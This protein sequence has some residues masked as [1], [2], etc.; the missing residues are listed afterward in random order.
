MEIP[1]VL[2]SRTDEIPT[3][4]PSNVSTSVCVTH[5]SEVLRYLCVQHELV[6][7]AHSTKEDKKDKAKINLSEQ[8][9]AFHNMEGEIEVFVKAMD[10]KLT[11]QQSKILSTSN[12]CDDCR[13][14]I[15]V[16]LSAVS[17]TFFYF[18]HLFFKNL[19]ITS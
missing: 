12:Q 13:K 14:L 3:Q 5:A 8:S 19:T 4:P 6:S 7:S 1:L 17:G 10:S 9:Y 11:S 15:K 16:N 2:H 18:L